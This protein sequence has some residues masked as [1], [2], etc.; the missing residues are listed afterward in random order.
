MKLGL[1][2]LTMTAMTFG[3][4]I[5]IAADT[6]NVRKVEML[7]V[8]LPAGLCEFETRLPNNLV[9]KLQERSDLRDLILYMLDECPELGLTLADVAT[10]S[11]APGGV[12][13]DDDDAVLPIGP[14]GVL[15]VDSGGDG[16]PGGGGG[17]TGGSGGSD[18]D[19]G[20]DATSDDD[21]NNGHGNDPGKNDPSNPGKS[22]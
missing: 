2:G 8:T 15:V 11:L 5:A 20:D 17:N 1:A 10:A 4:T 13:R 22:R 3:A 16:T 14:N 7:A 19:G 18:D 6:P 12:E 21:G 9:D